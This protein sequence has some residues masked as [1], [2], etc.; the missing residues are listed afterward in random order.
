MIR[1][2]ISAEYVLPAIVISLVAYSSTI[3]N[4]VP[5]FLYDTHSTELFIMS[6]GVPTI[7]NT[8]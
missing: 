8:L 7:S 2:L 3:V 1:S 5:D 4:S 6:A